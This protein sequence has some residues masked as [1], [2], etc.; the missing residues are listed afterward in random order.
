MAVA[1]GGAVGSVARHG[2]N[3]LVTRLN[4]HAVPYATAVVNIIGCLTIGWLAGMVATGNLRMTT[5][6]RAFV[7]VGVLGG[8]TTFSSLGLDTFVLVQDGERS[9]AFWNLIVQIGV[10]LPAVFVGYALGRGS[11]I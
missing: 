1:I 5:T 6:M 3:V 8:F 9:A 4:G 2:V 10:G 11:T 7:F